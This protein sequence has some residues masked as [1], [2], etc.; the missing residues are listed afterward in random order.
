VSTVEENI[1]VKS[2]EK[3]IA[4]TIAGKDNVKTAVQDIVNMAK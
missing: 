1:D 4:N 2:V 3:D